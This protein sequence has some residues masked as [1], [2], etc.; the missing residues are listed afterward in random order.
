[1]FVDGNIRL[2][3]DME[4]WEKIGTMA[5]W[6]K[7]SQQMNTHKLTTRIS[8]WKLDRYPMLTFEGTVTFW[9]TDGH[10]NGRDDGG[11]PEIYRIDPVDV[12][13][14]KARGKIKIDAQHEFWPELES[15]LMN[16]ND[17]PLW[18][19]MLEKAD[20][21]RLEMM[22]WD[23]FH[24]HYDEERGDFDLPDE[25]AEQYEMMFGESDEDEDEDEGKHAGP[26]DPRFPDL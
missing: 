17:N 12:N 6:S 9:F 15:D 24:H 5:G 7:S 13:A 11:G 21:D 20:R 22:A 26:K 8:G 14:V 23:R 25:Y 18:N 10:P 16:F 3:M 1:M 4:S 2:V 19:A